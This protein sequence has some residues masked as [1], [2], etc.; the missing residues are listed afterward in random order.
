MEL[1]KFCSPRSVVGGPLHLTGASLLMQYL[2]AH[3]VNC[4]PPQSYPDCEVHQGC[5]LV[6]VGLREGLAQ[7]MAA[8]IF[9]LLSLVLDGPGLHAICGPGVI[10]LLHELGL[11][12]WFR[13]GWFEF[14]YHFRLTI[15]F[16]V[17]KI[18]C[19]CFT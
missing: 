5:Q 12:S 8:M 4:L 9:L 15:S 7:A 11:V 2:I 18:M 16:P 17:P 6:T 3:C 1:L 13:I 14:V 10:L 19:P